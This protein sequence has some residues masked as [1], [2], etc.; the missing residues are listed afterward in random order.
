MRPAHQ[1]LEAG[2]AP[3]R[4]V[5]QRLVVRPQHV[6]LDGVAQIDLDLAAGLGAGIHPGFEEAEGAAEVVLG[7]GQRHVGVLQQ[8]SDSSPSPGDIAMP[9]LAPMTTE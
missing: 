7:A 1:R 8:L 2:D 6:V 4:K 3:G 5:D 9:M